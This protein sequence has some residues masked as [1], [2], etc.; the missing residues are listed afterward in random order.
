MNSLIAIL[1]R[2]AALLRAAVLG[3]AMIAV[4]SLPQSAQAARDKALEK[5]LREHIEVLASDDFGGR[6]PGTEGEAKTLRYLGRQWFDIGLQS[7]TNDPANPWFAPVT[8]VAREP[9]AS[10][11]Q[12]FA[13]GR[14]VPI[15]AD[16]LLL[17]TSGRRSLVR[18][19]A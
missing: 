3:F 5:R 1:G 10:R 9:A 17:V 8:L 16:E 7:G 15:S 14:H 12:F 2:N 19:Q 6:E 11:A 13:A 4:I 18:R